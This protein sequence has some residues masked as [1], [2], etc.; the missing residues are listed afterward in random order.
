MAEMDTPRVWIGCLASYNAGRLIGEWVDAV[1]LDEMNECRDRVAAQAVE[2]A[3][4]AGEYPVYFGDPEEFFLAD[5]EGFGF[6]VG[7]YVDWAKLATV[8]ALIAEHG[9]PFAA[10]LRWYDDNYSGDVLEDADELAERFSEAFCG[11]YESAKDYAYEYVEECWQVPE[12]LEGYLD[13]DTITRDLF[14]HGSY[15]FVNV[16]YGRGYVFRT[17]W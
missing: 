10:F 12:H 6:N 1:D 2:A 15:T 5:N 14:D 11:E 7:E 8:G 13:W 16:T 4:A 3:K 9:E 17:D